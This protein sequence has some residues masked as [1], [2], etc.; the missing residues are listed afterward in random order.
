MTYTEKL[1]L[2]AQFRQ[3]T[4]LE[5]GIPEFSRAS[6]RATKVSHYLPGHEPKTREQSWRTKKK[7]RKAA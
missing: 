3:G 4:A 7:K 1:A 2:A 6:V 5:T